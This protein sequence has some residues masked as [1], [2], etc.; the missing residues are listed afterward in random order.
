MI[1]KM[2]IGCKFRYFS[3]LIMQKILVYLGL[4]SF[5]EIFKK[6]TNR[7]WKNKEFLDNRIENK[8]LFLKNKKIDIS[9][10]IV[11]QGT[12]WHCLDPLI[13]YLLGSDKVY[14][15]D[16][17]RWLTK[18]NLIKSIEACIRKSHEIKNNTRLN[19]ID[20]SNR[21]NELI[22]IIE[23]DK[24][25]LSAILERIQINYYCIKNFNYDN[26]PNKSINL[27]YTDSVLQRMQPVDLRQLAKSSKR[28]LVENSAIC[29]IIDCKDFQSITNKDVPELW[30]LTLSPFLFS[31]ISSKYINYQN[32]LRM[33]EFKFF[34]NQVG[35]NC[36][37]CDKICHSFNVKFIKENYK[38]LK[39]SEKYTVNDIAISQFTLLA[40][41]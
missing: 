13:F 39:L 22:K 41:N 11:E 6:V 32:R 25:S 15:Y 18:D 10:N 17:S 36:I 20:F 7:F 26:I 19:E 34:F 8:L 12:G 38:K 28:I 37:I 24:L 40:T 33:P 23:N 16:T 27:F 5:Q 30:Y 2:T 14:T 3:K 9:G 4:I 1:N 29:H 35:F 31:L 21:I